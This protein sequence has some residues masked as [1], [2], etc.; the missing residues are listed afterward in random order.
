M[1]KN[2]PELIEAV[3]EL[4][5]AVTSLNAK[6]HPPEQIAQALLFSLTRT[7]W[8]HFN[9]NQNTAKKFAQTLQ[10]RFM[11]TFRELN[12]ITQEQQK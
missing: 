7:T 2:T 10:N 11:K 9:G 3:D 4:G 5:N 8:E 1:T 12:K 6:G